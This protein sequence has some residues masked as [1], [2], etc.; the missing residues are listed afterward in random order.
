MLL[1][2]P[3]LAGGCMTHQLWTDSGF[4]SWNEPAPAV[5]LQLFRDA[6]H[7][8]VLVV[9]QEYSERREKIRERAYFVNEN[10]TPVANPFTPKFVDLKTSRNLA[11]VTIFPVMPTNSI[12][13]FYAVAETN[14]PG[15]TLFSGAVKSG[16]H[17][18]PVYDDGSGRVKRIALTPVAATVDLTIVGGAAGV[19]WLYA[20]GPGLGGSR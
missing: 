15:F 3:L 11:P 9:Y 14:N 18:L 17:P 13:E 19:L 7:R 6:P 12:G 16:P 10:Q 1:L 5:G 8:R 4:D 20:E 2:L